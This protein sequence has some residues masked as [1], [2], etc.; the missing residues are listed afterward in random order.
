MKQAKKR[1]RTIKGVVYDLE[2]TERTPPC[3][4]PKAAPP[5]AA[6]PPPKAAPKP[7]LSHHWSATGQASQ[8]RKRGTVVV[9]DHRVLER[10]DSDRERLAAER[11]LES[12][13][14]ARK[15]PV[16]KQ[17]PNAFGAKPIRLPPLV[18]A[19]AVKVG[20]K[21]TVTGYGKFAPVARAI[22][23]AVPT[24]VPGYAGVVETKPSVRFVTGE[25]EGMT[26][27]VS[28]E[29]MHLGWLGE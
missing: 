22:V 7:S 24:G 28:W 8:G 2:P 5:K 19:S 18:K 1:C 12:E 3:G 4:R 16:V 20:D 29:Y 17:N 10:Q 25:N 21:V 15:R 27:Y 23:T 26:R 9:N 13:R 14:K 11:R 6:P